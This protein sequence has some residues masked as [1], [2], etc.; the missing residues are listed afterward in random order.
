[1][2]HV[3]ESTA[4]SPALLITLVAADELE[5]APRNQI[6]GPP[7]SA[8]APPKTSNALSELNI[9]VIIAVMGA[10]GSGKST[11]INLVSGSELGVG[12]GLRSCTS[13]V[14]ATAPF[15]FQGRRVVLFDTPGFDDT[16][17]SDTDI[18]T[19]VATFLATTYEHGAKLAGVIYMH[20][21]ND[22]RMGGIAVRS[23]GMFRE[24]CGDKSLKNVAI[25]TNFWSEVKPDTGNAREAE[26][27]SDFFKSALAKQA[28]LLRHDGTLAGASNIVAA[29][30]GN[31]PMALR[32]QEEMVIEKKDILQTAAGTVLNHELEKQARKHEEE[33]KKIKMDM[34]AAAKARDEETQEELEEAEQKLKA[35]MERV[36]ADSLKLAADHHEDKA[37]MEQ[38]MMDMLNMANESQTQMKQLQEQLLAFN[39]KAEGEREEMEEMKKLVADWKRKNEE[40]RNRSIFNGCIIA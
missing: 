38:R 32:I 28:K 13:D 26:L 9:D 2:H 1:M 19:L 34:E 30:M 16:S 14:E 18:L 29:I 7:P 35:M 36:Q 17:K 8:M 20:R 21:I 15:D 5:H 4:S 22:V 39:Q 40:Q 12:T 31:D 25:V 27:R 33:L 6:P 24:L 10:T 3:D 11:F 23:F 37:R